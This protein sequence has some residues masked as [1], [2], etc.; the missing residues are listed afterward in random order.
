MRDFQIRRGQPGSWLLFL[1]SPRKSNQ[2]ERDP[3][4]LPLRGTLCCS[5]KRA[6]VQLAL[7]AQTVLADFSRSCCAAR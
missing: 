1:V 5:P 2:K 6:A 4:S 3:G 7:R